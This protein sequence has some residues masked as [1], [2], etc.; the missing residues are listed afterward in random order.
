MS[1]RLK[2]CSRGEYYPSAKSAVIYCRAS[3][4]VRRPRRTAAA[5]AARNL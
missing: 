3:C 4:G 5:I 1:L 2:L